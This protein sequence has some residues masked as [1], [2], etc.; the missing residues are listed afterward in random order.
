MI[1]IFTLLQNCYPELPQQYFQR[2]THKVIKLQLFPNLCKN[3]SHE[4]K[5][6]LSESCCGVSV[7]MHPTHRKITV[8]QVLREVLRRVALRR[9]EKSN[10][11]SSS[12]GIMTPHA[13][14]SSLLCSKKKTF[15]CSR[16]FTFN[17][18]DLTHINSTS[19]YG[20]IVQSKRTTLQKIRLK[21][22]KSITK[23]MHF[24][25]SHATV[26]IRRFE[27]SFRATEPTELPLLL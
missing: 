21:L 27:G 15:T 23:A 14:T 22:H 7:D 5:G 17:E 3:S 26:L 2:L 12:S 1:R 9:E 19:F 18:P 20:L 24:T 16:F 6:L 25:P 13:T 4:P 11:K 8:L 10:W